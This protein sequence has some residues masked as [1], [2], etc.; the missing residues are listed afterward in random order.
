M[1]GFKS[2]QARVIQFEFIKNRGALDEVACVSTVVG[3]DDGS[4]GVFAGST[5]AKSVRS[6]S[7]AI[8]S[9][10]RISALVIS[11]GGD[12]RD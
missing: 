12:Q 7:A 2:R 5:C 3:G 9:M 1:Q 10:A 6:P 8:D 11:H 4:A